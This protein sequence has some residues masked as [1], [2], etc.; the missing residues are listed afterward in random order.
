[1]K[2]STEAQGWLN[3]KVQ[4]VM[5]AHHLSEPERA[6]VHYELMS[7]LHGAGE[8]KARAAGREEV[9]VGDLQAALLEMGGEGAVAE[10]FVAPRAKPLQRAGVVQRTAAYVVDL[11]II[12]IGWWAL[13]FAVGVVAW[14]FMLPFGGA[15]RFGRT[16]DP[17]DNWP[18][19]MVVPFGFFGLLGLLCLGY[20][21]FFEAKQGR[22]FGKQA[23]RLAVRRVDGKPL[24]YRETFIRNLVKVFPPLLLID[25]L[26]MLVFFPQEKQRVSDRIAETVVVEGG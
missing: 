5:Q 24:T 25:A 18:W 20:F 22:T 1:V 19:D 8:E 3:A 7:H 13:A 4:E 12:A 26:F 23:F 14:M 2:L 10:A 9:T 6:G 11:F 17:F 21:T 15:A 16:F